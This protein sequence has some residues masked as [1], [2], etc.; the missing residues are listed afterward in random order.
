MFYINH[1]LSKQSKDPDN[2]FGSVSSQQPVVHWSDLLHSIIN[3]R[4]PLTWRN[5]TDINININNGWDLPHLLHT[6][7]SQAD[8]CWK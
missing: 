1:L 3:Y 4:N 7:L 8:L 6:T 5:L 2:V